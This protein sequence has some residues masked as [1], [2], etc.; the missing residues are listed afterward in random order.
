MKVNP[1]V[2][3]SVAAALLILNAA[4]SA[5]VSTPTGLSTGGPKLPPTQGDFDY[6][7][8]EPY[9]FKSHSNSSPVVARDSSASPLAHSYSICYVNGF[10]TQPGEIAADS[11]LSEVV[12]RNSNDAL[13]VDPEWPDEYVLDPGTV[14]HREIIFKSRSSL[15]RSCAEK[16]FD[17]V[18]IDNL[19]TWTRFADISEEGAKALAKKY[20]DEA[21]GGVNA[22]KQ[23]GVRR[24]VVE[25]RI[26]LVSGSRVGG[27]GGC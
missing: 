20:V 22:S 14:K 7:L 6:Q 8:S 19:D 24:P 23:H 10:Q 16:G 17:A 25:R 2:L 9:D 5:N 12:L 21:H 15:I 4:C 27:V 13:V 11:R 18:E 26:L 1:S 3:T